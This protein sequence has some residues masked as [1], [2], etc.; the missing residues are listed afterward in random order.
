M[1][2]RYEADE[3]MVLTITGSYATRVRSY[4][5][6]MEEVGPAS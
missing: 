2:A 3:V 6:L 5:L 4:E 1:A